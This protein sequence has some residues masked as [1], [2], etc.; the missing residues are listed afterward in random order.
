MSKSILQ[1]KKECWFCLTEKNLATHHVFEGWGLREK[2]EQYGLKVKLCNRHHNTTDEG[3]HFNYNM[4]LLL[5]QYA[6]REFEKNYSHELFMKE[7]RVNWLGKEF[8]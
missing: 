4:D 2:S 8:K 5:K 3:V 7:F 1:T 6:Q